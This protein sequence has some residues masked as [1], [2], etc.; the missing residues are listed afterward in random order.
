MDKKSHTTI[1]LVFLIVLWIIIKFILKKDY[2]LWIFII[3]SI[4]ATWSPDIDKAFESA[5]HRSIIFHSIVFPVVCFYI[6]LQYNLA[7]FSF[8]LLLTV[9]VVGLHCLCD[10]RFVR[11][12][13]VG[14]YTIKILQVP[15]ISI[16][17]RKNRKNIVVW[18]TKIGLN[19]FWSTVWLVCNFVVA[20]GLL[21]GWMVYI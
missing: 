9:V 7:V 3:L 6:T 15:D 2:F 10:I 20:M 17:D 21:I 12:K 4:P 19:G 16:W 5:G 8:Y 18:K 1:T 14:F 13:R 11:R